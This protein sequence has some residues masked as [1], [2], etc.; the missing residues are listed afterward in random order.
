M[1]SQ[2]IPRKSFFQ[3]VEAFQLLPIKREHGVGHA[4]CR[5]RRRAKK[6][7]REQ[8][9]QVAGVLNGVVEVNLSKAVKPLPAIE[10]VKAQ[11]KCRLGV[12][13]LPKAP[14]RPF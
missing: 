5:H 8:F 7:S 13:D 14:C 9:I 10:L 3:N 1:L 4:G 11:G 2:K 12:I 6:L